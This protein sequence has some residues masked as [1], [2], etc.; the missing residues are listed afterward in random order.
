MGVFERV[1]R[2]IKSAEEN[3]PAQKPGRNDPCWCGSGIKYKKCHLSQ[4]DKKAASKSCT[5]NC[6]PS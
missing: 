6:G 5:P 1:V 2:A 4:D 3:E